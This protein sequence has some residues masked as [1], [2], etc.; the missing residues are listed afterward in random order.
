MQVTAPEMNQK[1][2]LTECKFNIEFRAQ[3]FSQIPIKPYAESHTRTYD[4]S[5]N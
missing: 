3:F 1:A 5:P 2:K 4:I